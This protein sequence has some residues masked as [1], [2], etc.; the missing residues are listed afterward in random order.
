MPG[1]SKLPSD[2]DGRSAIA[3]GWA[4]SER[5]LSVGLE[6][7]LPACAGYWVDQRWGWTPWLTLVGAAFGFTLSLVHL[8]QL[9]KELDRQNRRRK[10]AE[11]DDA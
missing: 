9:T 10:S 2:D 7:M 4:W 1:K 6:M 11:S 8:I 3:K 5:I